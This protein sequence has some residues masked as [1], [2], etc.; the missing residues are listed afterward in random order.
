MNQE[1]QNL[2]LD[3]EKKVTWSEVTSSDEDE[4]QLEI[5]QVLK[6]SNNIFEIKIIC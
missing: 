5:H 3:Q 4:E 6:L 2:T 1:T